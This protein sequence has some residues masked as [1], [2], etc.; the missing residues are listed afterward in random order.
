MPSTHSS[1]T[2]HRS[3]YTALRRTRPH[4]ARYSTTKHTYTTTLQ[5]H[6][7]LTL[8]LLYWESRGRTFDKETR[9]SQVL[10]S[11]GCWKRHC[12][13]YY[14]YDMIPTDRRRRDSGLPLMYDDI[15]QCYN[16]QQ[17]LLFCL[18]AFSQFLI[19][20][21]VP[22]SRSLVDSYSGRLYLFPCLL[23]HCQ[24]HICIL[25]D[26]YTCIH[27]AQHFHP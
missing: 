2:H 10:T 21:D 1:R 24:S 3:S 6:I 7:D 27:R 26:L 19:W 9:R 20:I 23:F 12:L 22:T 5:L 14:L 8:Q 15:D 17:I 4:L 18:P 11:Q 13:E 16:M 25:I